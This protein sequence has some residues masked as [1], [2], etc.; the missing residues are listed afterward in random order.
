M[1]ALKLELELEPELELN[2]LKLERMRLK[3]MSHQSNDFTCNA[4]A[5]PP[6]KSVAL[7]CG[8][9]QM[10]HPNPTGEP[11]EP[12]SKRLS[13][14]FSFSVSERQRER[15]RERQVNKAHVLFIVFQRTEIYGTC[16]LAQLVRSLPDSAQLSRAP[17]HRLI[18]P[19]VNALRVGAEL[20]EST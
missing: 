9:H 3:L 2:S 11:C 4:V 13:E 5:K 18:R 12:L 16:L 8:P 7:S 14:L 17:W 20:A 10:R 6:T 1:V 19:Q 15:E